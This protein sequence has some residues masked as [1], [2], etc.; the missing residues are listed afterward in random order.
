MFCQVIRF[1]TDRIDD[2]RNLTYRWATDTEGVRTVRRS[3]LYRDRDQ[4]NAYILVALF[5]SYDSAMINSSL[6]ETQEMAEEM[7]KVVTGLEY[8]NYDQIDVAVWA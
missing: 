6:P 3:I 7:V 1:R 8:T 4:G 5:D 2:I